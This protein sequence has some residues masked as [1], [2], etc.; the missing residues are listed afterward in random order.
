MAPLKP[1]VLLGAPALQQD[2]WP[3]SHPGGNPGANLKSIFHRCYLFEVAF[4]WELTKDTIVLP[5]GCLQG[6]TEPRNAKRQTQ[7]PEPETRNLRPSIMARVYLCALGSIDATNPQG[8]LK[9][10]GFAFRF[11]GENRWNPSAFFQVS[12]RKTRRFESAVRVVSV[13][14]LICWVGSINPWSLARE[15]ARAH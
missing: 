7:R 9:S 11:L 8:P 15:R 1:S 5:M 13:L 14:R 6:D 2:S 10:T 3:P 4:I 12:E